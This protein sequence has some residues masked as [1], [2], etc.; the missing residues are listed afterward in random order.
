MSQPNP[1]S[2]DT[3]RDAATRSDIPRD[4][5]IEIDP[6][7]TVRV[8]DDGIREV[9]FDDPELRPL[10]PDKLRYHVPHPDAHPEL[11]EHSDVPIRPLAIALAGIAGACVFT[12]VLTYWLFNHY[13]GQQQALERPRTAVSNAAPN[14]PEPRLQ[15]IPGFSNHHTDDLKDLTDHYREQ[16]EGFAPNDGAQTARVPI[17][18]AMDLALQ[19]NMFPV[20]QRGAGDNARPPAAAPDRTNPAGG[21]NQAGPNNQRGGNPP[22]RGNAGTPR[23]GGQ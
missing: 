16:L 8:T 7:T 5:S 2:G 1:P 19:R 6:R 15:G 18:R 20:A 11:H 22:P 10:P 9:G 14:V 3:P 23:G 21:S 4:E 12:L 17:D 13:K